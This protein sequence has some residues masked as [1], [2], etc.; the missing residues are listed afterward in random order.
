MVALQ[1]YIVRFYNVCV[2][3]IYMSFTLNDTT[4][5]NTIIKAQTIKFKQKSFSM[6]VSIITKATNYIILSLID[7]RSISLRD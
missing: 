3:L 5:R 7:K 1:H 2:D 6:S 4:I